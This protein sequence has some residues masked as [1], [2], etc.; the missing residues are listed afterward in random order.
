M[1][2]GLQPCVRFACAHQDAAAGAERG[3]GSVCGAASPRSAHIRNKS[4]SSI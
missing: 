2:A 1:R 3:G 4:S